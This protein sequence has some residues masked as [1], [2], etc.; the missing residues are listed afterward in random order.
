MT[1]Q[2]KNGQIVSHVQIKENNEQMQRHLVNQAH[3]SR[4]KYQ[5]LSSKKMTMYEEQ[6]ALEHITR[7]NHFENIAK[8]LL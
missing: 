3:K 5:S 2:E 4:M 8:K 7:A 6:L 1:T